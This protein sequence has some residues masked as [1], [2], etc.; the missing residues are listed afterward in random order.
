MKGTKPSRRVFWFVSTCPLFRVVFLLST[1]VNLGSSFVATSQ[2][3]QHQLDYSTTRHFVS[4]PSASSTYYATDQVDLSSG[5]SA[6]V[7]SKFPSNSSSSKTTI[8]SSSRN[9]KPPLIFIHGSFHSAWCWCEHWMDY[10]VER[11][12]PVVALSL[13]GTGG[14]FA[15]EGVK[16]VKIGEHAADIQAFLS[17]F[18]EFLQNQSDAKNKKDGSNPAMWQNFMGSISPPNSSPAKAKPVL[19][20][21]SFGGSAVMKYME[22]FP[23]ELGNLSGAIL[24]CS[25]PP[26]GNGP[27]TL[28]FLRRSLVQSWKITKGFAL[29]KCLD[30]LDLCRDI[31]FG[32]PVKVIEE[33]RDDGSTVSIVEDYGVSEE[34][35]VRYQSYFQRDTVATIDVTDFVK[36]LPSKQWDENRQSP[37]LSKLPPCLVLG[38]NR[39]YLVDREGVEETANYFG[40]DAQIIDSPHDIMLG[41]NWKLGAEAIFHWLEANGM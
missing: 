38:A 27:M 9:T 25:V 2:L 1:V 18:E 10:F 20:S 24:A 3:R 39:D 40:V 19:I 16:N 36:H 30:Q 41:K 11:G 5:V 8:R 26:S 4:S 6:Q 22:T 21:H 7:L 15:G 34:D 29:K 33:Q 17:Q 37:F 13:R 32:G 14:T 31:F 35:L 12:Y 23:E 28:R